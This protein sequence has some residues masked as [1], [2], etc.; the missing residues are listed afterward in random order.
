[1]RLKVKAYALAHLKGVPYHLSAG[2]LGKKAPDVNASYFGLQCAY[3][4]WYAWNAF[5]YD[6]DADG[7][8]LVTASDILYSD[9]VEIVQ[10][11][12]L[13]IVYK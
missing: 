1:M 8:R 9:C 3:L 5:G 7:G 6:V 10:C 12:G 11:Y 2:F 4:V 13:D